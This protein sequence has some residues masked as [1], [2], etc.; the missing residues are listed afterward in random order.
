MV[1]QV[2]ELEEIDFGPD[3]MFTTVPLA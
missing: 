1:E 3:G 2:S